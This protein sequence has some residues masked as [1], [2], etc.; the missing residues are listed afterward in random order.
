MINKI[1]S[2]YTQISYVESDGTNYIDTKL[3]GKSGL[4]CKG[5]MSFVTVPA[6][7]TIIGSRTGNTRIYLLHYYIKPTIGYMHYHQFGTPAIAN[8]IY[9]FET[10]LN[11][12]EQTFT[13]NGE[14][15][16][17][18]NIEDEINTGYTMYIFAL[19]HDGETNWFTQGRIY[20]LKI[21]DN[22]ML[23]RDYVPVKNAEGV[24]GLYDKVTNMFYTSATDS[25]LI[26]Q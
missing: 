25:P 1:P 18:L 9:D 2:Q 22:N 13:W 21:Y 11:A 19:N 20:Y 24:Y 6:D 17:Q 16:G 5:R 7:G 8:T 14:V 23:V 10:I 12:G 26:G 3:I 15:I 4:S